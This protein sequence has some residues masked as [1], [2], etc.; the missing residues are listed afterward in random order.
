ME[1]N[2]VIY[3][4]KYSF[5]MVLRIIGLVIGGLILAVC[6]AFVFGYF[7]M[8][9]WN[10]LMPVIFNLP[11]ITYWQAFG[12]IIL[13]RLLVGSH[14]KGHDH[15]NSHSRQY[16]PKF[17]NWLRYGKRVRKPD[18]SHKWEQWDCYDKWWE[19]EGENAFNEYKNKKKEE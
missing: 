1:T 18:Y 2:N 15:N 16:K 5:L 11:A 12:I 4:R 3:E 13:A 10:W 14:G 8:L 6:L 9:L 7:V 17:F 19:E